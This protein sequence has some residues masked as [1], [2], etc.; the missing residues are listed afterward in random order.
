MKRFGPLLLAAV[1]LLGAC[2]G[3]GEE[4][5]PDVSAD[6]DEPVLTKKEI[7]LTVWEG[8]N[9]VGFIEEAAAAFQRKYPNIKVRTA[10]TE[11]AAA[12]ESV[13]KGGNPD[14]FAVPHTDVRLLA[15][16]LNVLPARDQVKTKNAVFPACAQAA[17]AGGVIYGYPVSSET[18][19]LFYNKRLI[20]QDEVP[21]TWEELTEFA[22]DFRDGERYGFV[23][24]LETPH[25]TAPFLSARHNRPFGP[26]GENARQLN[27]ESSAAIEGM[28]VL[29]N[30]R[31]AVGLSSEELTSGA[32]ESLF[33][34]GKAAICVAGPWSIA[35]FGG[36]DFGVAPLP[37]FP[38]EEP[39]APLAFANVM[40]VSAY[41]EYP[42]EASAFAAFLLTEEMQRLRAELTGELPS[43]EAGLRSPAY[44]A[45]FAA[46]MADAYAAPSIPEAAAYW[47]AFSEAC[48]LI[49]DGGTVQDEL[50]AAADALRAPGPGEE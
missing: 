41:S 36:I 18:V 8:E 28:T 44:A 14:L 21:A 35:R 27:L 29:K 37:A 5:S 34:S 48:A 32:V 23:L 33:A 39:S 4:P 17:T 13:R 19:A 3:L 15:E 42:D 9:A 50:A 24:P 43:V 30:L 26:N 49:W 6:P 20:S 7:T 45:G 40:L 1:L 47:K 46:Q 31:A 25:T 2:S 12:S 16:T 22:R 11:P 38:G 10:V